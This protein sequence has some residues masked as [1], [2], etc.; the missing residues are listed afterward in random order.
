VALLIAIVVVLGAITLAIW[1]AYLKPASGD[2]ASV[3]KMAFHYR[4]SRL[5]L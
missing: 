1:K 3:E 5:L 2:V 4:M